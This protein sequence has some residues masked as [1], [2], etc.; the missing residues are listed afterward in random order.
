MAI[1]KD[2]REKIGNI[3]HTVRVQ[4]LPFEVWC[5]I[6]EEHRD[7]VMD[8][9][10]ENTILP[11][12]GCDIDDFYTE[13]QYE[14]LEEERD[15]WEIR[16]E[17]LEEER[18]EAVADKDKLEQEYIQEIQTLR[19][20]NELTL[21]TLDIEREEHQEAIELRDSII[22]ELEAKLRELEG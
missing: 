12:C 17:E 19:D 14:D 22:D 4:V 10:D 3:I 5:P 11:E 18:D 20:N 8:S 13:E 15:R 1:Y 6:C 16:A 2:K 21:N 7:G 9:M